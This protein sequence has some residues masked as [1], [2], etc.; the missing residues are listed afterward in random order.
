MTSDELKQI[1]RQS[2]GA[3][4]K[5]MAEGDS[6]ALARFVRLAQMQVA[7]NGTISAALGIE[8]MGRLRSL[9]RAM[10]EIVNNSDLTPAARMQIAASALQE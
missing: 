2:F 8:M 9:E 1:I 10:V 5:A 4:K 3:S 7:M 6:K